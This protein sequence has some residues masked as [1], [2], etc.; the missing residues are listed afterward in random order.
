MKRCIG[1]AM[2]ALLFLSTGLA[3]EKQETKS[4]N[5]RQWYSGKFGFY[6]PSEGLN[7][8][9]MLGVDGIT[10]F[11]HYNFFLSGAIDLYPKQTI[12]IFKDPKP[13]ISQQHI[14]VLPL[15]VNFGYKVFDVEDADSRGYIGVGAGY[16][17]YFYNV[18]YQT[19]SGGILGGLTTRSQTNSSGS[20]FGTI[21]ARALIGRIFV[22]PRFYIASKEEESIEGGFTYQVNPSGFAVTL[23]FQY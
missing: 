23:G 4:S 19:G 20:V 15:H 13:N 6:N 11:L 10:E 8:G 16:Y 1:F 14:I 17:F 18:D 7:N 12:D 5:T 3:Q 21:F 2:A 22:E 9:L